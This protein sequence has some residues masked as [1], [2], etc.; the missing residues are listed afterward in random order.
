[1]VGM[2]LELVIKS[3]CNLALV[4]VIAEG[5]VEENISQL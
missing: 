5:N 4:E 1:M 2:R 3:R